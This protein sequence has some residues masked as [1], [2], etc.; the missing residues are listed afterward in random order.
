MVQADC[1]LFLSEP[2]RLKGI[3]LESPEAVINLWLQVFCCECAILAGVL[4][5]SISIQFEKKDYEAKSTSILYSII[6]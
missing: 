3:V 5:L 6:I 1:T 4:E 2:E